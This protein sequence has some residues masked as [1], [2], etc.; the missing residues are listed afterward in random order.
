MWFLQRIWP[1]LFELYAGHIQCVLLN[2]CHSK[3]Q[4]DAIIRHVPY[5][6][7]MNREIPDE[8]AIAFAKTFYDA[9]G[10]GEEI[11]FAFKNAKTYLGLA[12]LPGKDIPEL[13]RQENLS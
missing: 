5:V 8:T 11:P 4:S 9:L 6:I 1:S 2:A 13:I 7:G 10:A 12:K 3:L